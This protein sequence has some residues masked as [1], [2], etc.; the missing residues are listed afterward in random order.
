M[1]LTFKPEKHEYKSPDLDIDWLSVTSFVAALKQPFD[2]LKQAEKSSK[3]KR[4]KWYGMPVDHI[5]FLWAAEG[6]R[7]SLMGTW[8]HDQREQDLMEFTTI[9]RHGITVPII[10]PIYDDDTKIAPKQSLEDGVYPEHFVYLQSRGVCGQADR[11]EVV[12]SYVNISDYKTNKEIKL[13]GFTNWEGITTKMLEPVAHMDDCHITHYGLQL[14]LYLYMI[15]KH[16]PKLKP[17][18]LTVEH[19]IFEEQGKDQYGYPVYKTNTEGEFMVKEVKMREVPY[20]RTEVISMLNFLEANR[21]LI[22][23]RKRS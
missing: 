3:N 23:S 4:S 14:S 9:E 21:E 15:L 2:A 12:N 13:V 22:K 19:I 5:L 10:R 20:Y 17:G 11:V 1:I 16:N 6:D 7:A 8:Y 18:K